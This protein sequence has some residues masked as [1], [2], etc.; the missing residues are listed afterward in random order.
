M[1]CYFQ[2]KERERERSHTHGG[3]H[4][5]YRKG[6]SG[7]DIRT[8]GA[9]LFHPGYR[10]DI[11]ELVYKCNVISKGKR[12]RERGHTHM[13]E[14]TINTGKGGLDWIYVHVELYYFIQ[15]TGMI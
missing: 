2:G 1:Q 15:D 12:E 4:Y 10:D 11:S 8:C 14:N 6:G 5:K 7:L 9:V 13:G 3:K